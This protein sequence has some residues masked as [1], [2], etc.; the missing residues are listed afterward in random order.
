MTNIVSQQRLRFDYADLH[1][2][3]DGQ[4]RVE[5]GFTFVNR[6][7]RASAVESS[8]GRGP[9]KAAASA[10]LRAI[11][12]AADNRFGC[13]LADLD[14]VQALGKNLIAV[15]VNVDFE[16]KQIQVFGSCQITSDEMDAA[17]RSALNATNRFFDLAIRS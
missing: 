1:Q 5:V 15:L 12:M 16:G 3:A 8:E 2:E 6:V 7:V 4:C 13:V 17:V 14:H 10:A 9:L 11:A